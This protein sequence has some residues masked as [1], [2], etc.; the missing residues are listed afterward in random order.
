MATETASDNPSPLHVKPH[1]PWG[2]PLAVTAAIAFFF[3]STFPVV[4]AF[5]K[6]KD[7]WPKWLGCARCQHRICP[8]D[9]SVRRLRVRS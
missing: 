9:S 7:N 5:V 2:R 8:R 3:S 6:D 4:A 1:V